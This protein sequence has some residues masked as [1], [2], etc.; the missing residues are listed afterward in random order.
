MGGGA[1]SKNSRVPEERN[2]AIRPISG[3]LAAS[4]GSRPAGRRS[5]R[6]YEHGIMDVRARIGF[7]PWAVQLGSTNCFAPQV[8]CGAVRSPALCQI[9]PDARFPRAAATRAQVPKGSPSSLR[10][11]SCTFADFR[12]PSYSF[13]CPRIASYV[14]VCF[15]MFGYG[16]VGLGIVGYVWVSLGMVAHI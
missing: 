12:I 10:I 6:I 13:V 11:P 4:Q 14:S 16:W 5:G 15:R 7:A 8:N 3:S 2:R 1:L 9:A